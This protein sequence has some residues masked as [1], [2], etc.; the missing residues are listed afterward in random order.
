MCGIDF[1]FGNW[2][3]ELLYSK[4]EN[5]ELDDFLIAAES[6]KSLD[7]S[8]NR[9]VKGTAVASA[10]DGKSLETYSAHRSARLCFHL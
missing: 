7:L 1:V 6:E 10:K 4:K 3:Q 8:Q 2:E 9:P 5:K